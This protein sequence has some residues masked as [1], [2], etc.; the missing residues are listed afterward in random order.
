MRKTLSLDD[1]ITDLL[2]QEIQRSGVSF[3]KALWQRGG[4]DRD[5][6]GSSAPV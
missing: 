1:D 3:K 5:A 6:R 4:G 2:N